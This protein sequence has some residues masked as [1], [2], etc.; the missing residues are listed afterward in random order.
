ML[1]DFEPKKCKVYSGLIKK[2]G[3]ISIEDIPNY[4]DISN[5]EIYKKY[6]LIIMQ[7][8]VSNYNKYEIF[9]LKF[10]YVNDFRDRIECKEIN[11]GSYYFDDTSLLY[12]V[13]E[14]KDWVKDNMPQ[15]VIYP[16]SI[17][18]IRTGKEKIGVWMNTSCGTKQIIEAQVKNGI[19]GEINFINKNSGDIAKEKIDF[20]N[21]DAVYEK[22]YQSILEG[23]WQ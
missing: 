21:N 17:V 8:L 5:I 15:C 14:V 4:K 19:V 22:L 6:S 11:V 23:E 18:D 3:R 7:Y 16:S 13:E 1:V 12:Y 9:P 2:L 20:F 10:F